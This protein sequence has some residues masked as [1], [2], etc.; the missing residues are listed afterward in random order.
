MAARE[1]SALA[2]TLARCASAT[3]LSGGDVL[4]LAGKA[5]AVVGNV[6]SEVLGHFV[7]VEHRPDFETDGGRAAQRLALAGHCRGDARQ[8]ALGGGEQIL[9]PAG[10]FG[11]Q[12]LVAADDQAFA[13]KIR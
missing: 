8:F 9:A 11:R 13:G 3:S 2:T 12:C 5:K 1:R 7:P 4:G 6:E 10:T